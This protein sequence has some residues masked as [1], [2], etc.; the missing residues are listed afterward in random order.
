ME[1]GAAQQVGDIQSAGSDITPIN[2]ADEVIIHQ[3]ETAG[4]QIGMTWRTV[5]AASVFISVSSSCFMLT[6][7]SPWEL[8]TTRTCSL[9]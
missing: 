6:R 8:R 2:D 7:G 5:M 3:L 9:C 1:K 4:A